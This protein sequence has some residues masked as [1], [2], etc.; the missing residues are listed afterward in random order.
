M[1]A[2]A[3]E[4]SRPQ[5]AGDIGQAVRHHDITATAAECDALA[6]RFGLI[7]L[8]SLV[9]RL[10]LH[11]DAAGIRVAGRFAAT[12]SQPCVA[13]GEP[14]TFAHDEAITLLL[15]ET[16]PDADEIE[17]ADSDLDAEPLLGDTIDLGELT[18]QALGVALDPYPR[19]DA[20][21]PGV[22]S[23]DAARAAASPFSVLK[24]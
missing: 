7:G 18:A 10:D 1:S 17:L 4:F 22:I 14:V 23:E 2:P 15:V 13:T 16:L 12:G 9:A 21:A 19:S 24:K 8:D 3:P 11:R 6:R 20:A 5:R